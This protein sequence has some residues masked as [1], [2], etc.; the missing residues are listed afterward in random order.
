MR[1]KRITIN[2]GDV[3]GARGIG[4]AAIGCQI[5]VGMRHPDV[6]LVEPELMAQQDL[7][8]LS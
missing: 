1:A 5:G 8:H 6:C 7:V 4:A 3:G 2:P